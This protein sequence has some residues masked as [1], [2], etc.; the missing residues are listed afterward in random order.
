MTNTN[1]QKI[2]D[3]LKAQKEY[4][5]TGETLEISF[6]K[7]MLGKFLQAMEKWEQKLADALWADLHKS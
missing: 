1:E 3:I 2:L 5:R 4:F 6:R 7:K